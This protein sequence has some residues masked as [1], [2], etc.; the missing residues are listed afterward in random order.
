[1][2]SDQRTWLCTVRALALCPLWTWLHAMRALQSSST[3]RSPLAWGWPSLTPRRPTAL[4][5]SQSENTVQTDGM[6][7]SKAEHTL[8][9]MSNEK[10]MLHFANRLKKPVHC[11]AIYEGLKRKKCTNMAFIFCGVFLF[12]LS[13]DCLFLSCSLWWSK[14]SS[15]IYYFCTYDNKSC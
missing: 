6:W 4:T 5:P 10:H 2:A 7:E 11:L 1:M 14:L 13:D 9:Q 15:T 8:L 12:L 3:R